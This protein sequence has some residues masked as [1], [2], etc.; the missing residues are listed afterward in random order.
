MAN[1]SRISVWGLELAPV[2]L[3]DT[4]LVFLSGVGTSCVG[5]AEMGV[6]DRLV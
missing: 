3:F 6:A 1:R 5:G 2:E 4:V